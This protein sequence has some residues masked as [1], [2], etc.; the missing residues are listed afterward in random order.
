MLLIR[1]L[2]ITDKSKIRDLT[3]PMPPEGFCPI[4]GEKNE[5][6][7]C[8]MYNCKCDITAINCDWPACV[9]QSCLEINCVC[10]NE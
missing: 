8:E 1:K 9:C 2:K 3:E 6:C 7:K 5:K 4:C 10:E